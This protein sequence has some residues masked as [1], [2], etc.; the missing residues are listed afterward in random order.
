[1]SLLCLLLRKTGKKDIQSFNFVIWEDSE[2]SRGFLG[3]P[4]LAGNS[5]QEPKRTIVNFE[6]QFS[7]INMYGWH[8]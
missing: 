4:F 6:Q 2:V 5:G 3:I 8:G 7:V 1:M